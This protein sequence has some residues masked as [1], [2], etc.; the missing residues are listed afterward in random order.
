[1]L[2]RSADDLKAFIVKRNQSGKIYCKDHEIYCM[3]CRKA[4]EPLGRLIDLVYLSEN[5]FNLKGICPHCNTTLFKAGSQKKIDL[6]LKIFTT[7]TIQHKRLV[8]TDH[9]TVSDN[10]KGREKNDKI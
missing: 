4:V 8:D 3:K 10:K 6:Y 7:Q 1:M 9:P 5:R 2:F